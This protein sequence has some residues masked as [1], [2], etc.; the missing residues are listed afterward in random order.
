MGEESPVSVL[1]NSEGGVSPFSPGADGRGGAGVTPIA[2]RAMAVLRLGNRFPN[3]GACAVRGVLQVGCCALPDC[4]TYA[5][6]SCV[7][8]CRIV[9]VAPSNVVGARTQ[10]SPLSA[11][12]PVVGRIVPSALP[13]AQRH[14]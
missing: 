11:S 13:S 5:H 9:C 6:A 7:G 10:L 4:A 1:G 12:S 2:A 3:V 8:L 14:W